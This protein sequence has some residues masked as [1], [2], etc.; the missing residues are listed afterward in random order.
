MFT[1]TAAPD[2]TLNLMAKSHSAGGGGST[3]GVAQSVM[4][5]VTS[6]TGSSVAVDSD[7]NWTFQPSEKLAD[8]VYSMT[9]VATNPDGKATDT[10]TF[11]VQDGAVTTTGTTQGSADSSGSGDG[12][13]AATGVDATTVAAG[14]IAALLA[15]A[16]GSLLFWRRKRGQREQAV[17]DTAGE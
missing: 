6:F 14:G 4:A 10:V 5:D 1:G 3:A 12:D 11:T 8:G 13:L 9:V 15:A 2:A 7:G 17:T 16:G